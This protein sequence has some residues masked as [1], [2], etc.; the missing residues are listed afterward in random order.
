MTKMDKEPSHDQSSISDQ[1]AKQHVRN[2]STAPAHMI[3]DLGALIEEEEPPVQPQETNDRFVN[4]NSPHD[5][6]LMNKTSVDNVNEKRLANREKSAH[7]SRKSSPNYHA[8][9]ALSRGHSGNKTIS[10]SAD[11]K[12]SQASRDESAGFK[13]NAAHG[14]ESDSDD[15]MAVRRIQD[16]RSDLD[17]IGVD[18]SNE[19]DHDT[20]LEPEEATPAYDHSGKTLYLDACKKFGV[21]PISYFLRHMNDNSLSMKHHG[22]AGEGMRPIAISL[23]SNA[24]ITTLDLTD[25]WLGVDGG[26]ALCEMLKEN[27]FITDLNLSD[28]NLNKCAAQLCEIIQKNDTLR[29][30]NLSGNGFDDVS[31]IHLTNLILTTTKLESL[32][33][34]HNRLGEKAGLMLGPAISENLC[35]KELDLSWNHLRR[36]GAIAVAAGVKSNVF[37]KKVNLS[38]N[39]FG[40]EASSALMDALKANNVLEEIDLTNNRLTTEGAV[41][42][43][44]GLTINETLKVLKVGKNPMQSAGCW[45]IAAAIL[46][47]PN[48]VLETVDFTDIIVNKDFIALWKQVEEQFPKLKTVHGGTEIPLKPKQRVHPLAKVTAFINARNIRLIDFFNKFD[49]DGSMNVSREEF[50]Q[51]ILQLIQETGINLSPEDIELLINELDVNED[52]AINYSELAV[53]QMDYEGKRKRVIPY[54]TLRPMTS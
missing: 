52:G 48:C 53:G 2:I 32:N 34:S 27:C 54:T 22:L 39:G 43:G 37:M 9:S 6:R 47:N 12:K 50:K 35:L 26:L 33:L 19:N 8:A 46:K 36:K 14:V 4:K 21:V 18:I 42:I 28:N 38:W 40:Q 30:V 13:Q 5:T 44:K 29:K 25:N 11:R 24:T 20:D 1:Q 7:G 23:V 17:I 49:K 15:D 45:A 51:G 3:S 10:R 16:N 31:A 41:L